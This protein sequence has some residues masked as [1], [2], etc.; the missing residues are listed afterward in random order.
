MA[1]SEN[2]LVVGRDGQVARCLAQI[3][4]H[5]ALPILCLGRPDVD[6]SNMDTLEAAL[7]KTNP[8]LT[9]NAAAYTAVD[10]AESDVDAAF[11]VNARGAENLARACAASNIPMIHISTDYV[12]D[13]TKSGPY[14]E[15]DPVAPL[16][17]YGKSKL[18]GE[19]AVRKN[20]DKH[21]ILRTSWVYS[22]FGNNFLKTML[23]LGRERDQIGVVND[24]LG[25]PTD[26]M[27]LANVI[28]E[29]TEQ[30]LNK[31]TDNWGTYHACGAKQATWFEF[32]QDIFHT[33]DELSLPTPHLNAIT[34]AEYPTPVTRPANSVL[35]CARLQQDWG[36]KVLG[37]DA[38]L[39]EV[40]TTASMA[41]V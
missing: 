19:I 9:I 22:E 6:I 14:T 4:A 32:A 13:G 1:K 11:N 30:I 38:R 12:F 40:I 18:E 20:C 2:I 37:Y 10:Q 35:D 41:Q 39:S 15:D 16:G 3:G 29:I 36:L 5:M 25:C 33:A 7:E 34:S 24:Q 26:A 28:L 17:N 31:N 27:A 8:V 23:R 21:L